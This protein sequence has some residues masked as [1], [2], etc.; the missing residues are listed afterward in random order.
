M[1]NRESIRLN[2]GQVGEV[3]LIADRIP[4]GSRFSCVK[5]TESFRIDEP[6]I[7][8]DRTLVMSEADQIYGFKC[9]PVLTMTCL[10]TALFGKDF[11]RGR[12]DRKYSQAGKCSEILEDKLR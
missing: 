9:T 1:R 5:E 7:K 10:V 12:V 2:T 3:T 8:M 6:S 4:L 11:E